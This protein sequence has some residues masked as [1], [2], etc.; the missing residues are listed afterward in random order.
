MW[1]CARHF[2]LPYGVRRPLPCV[3][4]GVLSI[5][6]PHSLPI[7]FTKLDTVGEFGQPCAY[8]DHASCGAISDARTGLRPRAYSAIIAA[9]VNSPAVSSCR[10]SQA[11]VAKCPALCKRASRRSRSWS[12]ATAWRWCWCSCPSMPRPLLAGAAVTSLT[13]TRAHA[14][15]CDPSVQS[16]ALTG[17]VAPM[18]RTHRRRLGRSAKLTRPEAGTERLCELCALSAW[19]CSWRLLAASGGFWRLL[20]AVGVTGEPRRKGRQAAVARQAVP[21]GGA[22]SS[23]CARWQDN[24]RRPAPP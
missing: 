4:L 2:V 13:S 23:C 1:R 22:W 5:Y 9:L 11:I 17:V 24:C 6:L 20:A 10:E 15:P 16:P 8:A 3:A 14:T 18:A 21:A 19:R 12:R 7:G